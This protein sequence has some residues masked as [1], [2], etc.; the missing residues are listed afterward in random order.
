[1]STPLPDAPN[2]EHLRKQAKDLHR[3]ARAGDP[4]ARARIAAHFPEA[5]ASDVSLSQ[6]QLT[7][8]RAYG[9]PSWTQLKRHVQATGPLT[10]DRPFRREMDYFEGRASG[11]HSVVA[12]GLP[13]A[14]FQARTIHPR[15]ADASLPTSGFTLDDARLVVARQHGCATWEAL[16]DHI[17]GLASGTRSEPFMDA[18]EAMEARDASRLRDI[19]A[20]HPE[21]V[22]ARGTNGNT[23]LGL[24][25]SLETTADLSQPPGVAADAGGRPSA[26]TEILLAA[27]ADVGASND[28]GWT[29]LHQAAYSN[30]VPLIDR[31]L[32]AG[33]AADVSAHGDGGTPLMMALFWGH[34]AAAERLARV[35]ATPENLRAAAGLGHLEMARAMVRDD[36]TLAPAAGSHRAFYRPHS[37]FPVWQPSDNPSEILDE[38]LVYAARNGRVEVM[39][40][41]IERGARVDAEPYN[42]TALH[43]AAS[44][45]QMEAV[46]LLLGRGADV[47]REASFGGVLG[48][49]PLHVAAW[50]GK[51]EA[52]TALLEAGADIA[53]RDPVYHG[54]P[55]GWAGH[56]GHADIRDYLLEAGAE[57]HLFHAIAADRQ[58]GVEA[59]L[60][61]DP[62]LVHHDDGWTL[63]LVDA[64]QQ[65]R[66]DIVHLLLERGADPQRADSQ[67]RTARAAALAAGQTETAELLP[68]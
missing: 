4:E 14:V 59:L 9:F 38:A 1:M 36:G 23:L 66:A 25:A 21:I 62:S 11:L 48:V 3:A 17:A 55:W 6:A 13:A 61:A 44:T 68:L 52:V 35:E 19:L 20:R 31:L 15:F 63:P 10:P 5:L 57:R 12:S 34:R 43:W 8:A 16:E 56:A 53:R 27:G 37:G 40:F 49:T 30:N 60:D 51:M 39:E 24:A 22:N 29:A 33:A 54:F 32:S 2:L 47:D 45:G 65:G 7:I 42:G 64:A 26:C 46:K 41:L 28:R 67:G 50:G 18:Y 58:D